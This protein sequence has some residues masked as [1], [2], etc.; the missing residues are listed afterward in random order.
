VRPWHDVVQALHRWRGPAQ[1]IE[2][3]AALARVDGLSQRLA[4][5]K[6]AFSRFTARR[7]P[8]LLP[9]WR[10]GFRCDSASRRESRWAAAPRP[11]API[12]CA[13]PC[14]EH[15]RDEAAHRL[16]HRSVDSR[17]IAPQPQNR[18]PEAE[19]SFQAAVPQEMRIDRTV[20]DRR[21]RRGARRSSIVSRQVRRLVFCFSWF[22]PERS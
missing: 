22:D 18:K 14:A 13:G 7:R 19:F 3:L 21:R 17:I 9:W 1:T 2:A 4:V 8:R 11:H 5:Q 6:S 16:A 12:C 10:P 15:V 20:D